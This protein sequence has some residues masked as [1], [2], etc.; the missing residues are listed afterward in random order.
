[1]NGGMGPAHARV[2]PVMHAN[3]GNLVT[4]K[5]LTATATATGDGP[6]LTVGDM[7]EAGVLPAS[8]MFAKPPLWNG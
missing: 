4:R 3:W 1:M 2:A 8:P 7:H 6:L 5:I